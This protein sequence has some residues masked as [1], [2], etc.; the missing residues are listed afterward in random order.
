[1][2]SAA[3]VPEFRSLLELVLHNG[4][5]GWLARL[6]GKPD[7]PDY[8]RPPVRW[9]LS[10][11]LLAKLKKIAV[12]A[13][14][15]DELDHRDWMETQSIDLSQAG[16]ADG[17]PFWFDYV[18]DI[19]D[20]QLCN[21]NLACL[22]LG[23]LALR[24]NGTLAAI[25]DP[26]QLEQGES[27]GP[28]ERLPRGAFLLVGG[29]TAYQ[30]ADVE[31]LELR[32]H[33][34]FEWA[35]Q[36][37]DKPLA[38]EDERK[39]PWLF[40][41]PGNHDLYDAL[42]GFNKF[43]V[44]PHH[45]LANPNTRIADFNRRQTASYVCLDLPHGYR[46][47]GMDSQYGK[48]DHRQSTQMTAWVRAEEEPG[49]EAPLRRKLI[50][51]TSQPSTVFGATTPSSRR[52]FEAA[53]LPRPFLA[54]SAALPAGAIHLDLSGDIHHYARYAKSPST[55]W[56]NY[57]SVVAGGGALAHATEDDSKN[58]HA[59][60][61]PPRALKLYPEP[62]V[63]F[64]TTSRR[65][66]RPWQI[67]NGGLTWLVCG[68]VAALG[69]YGYVGGPF[70]SSHVSLLS[71]IT[72]FWLS[73]A[74][75]QGLGLR[76][77][78][79]FA[80]TLT[81]LL[82]CIR[83]TRFFRMNA[84][85]VGTATPKLVPT[86]AYWPVTVFGSVAL[87]S[88]AIGIASSYHAGSSGARLQS[89]LPLLASSALWPVFWS[90]ALKYQKTLPAQRKVRRTTW[91][92]RLIAALPLALGPLCSWY[93]ARLF[94]PEDHR[95]GRLS[96]A[97]GH[98]AIL[99]GLPLLA[100]YQGSSR[101]PLPRRALLVLAALLLAICLL[102]VPGAMAVHGS[103]IAIAIAVG[104]TWALSA[105]LSLHPARL[106]VRLLYPVSLVCPLAVVSVLDGVSPWDFIAAAPGNV[107][108]GW[109]AFAL[110]AGLA[111]AWF[112]GYLAFALSF[113]CHNNEAGGA[114]RIDRFGH[115][116]RFKLEPQ[117]I[118]GYV[119]GLEHLADSQSPL[120]PFLIEIF[121]VGQ[122]SDLPSTRARKVAE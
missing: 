81:T 118:T 110:G 10:R 109:V 97:V 58:E 24:E 34:P 104:V 46:L 72:Q 119:I 100:W 25:A 17:Q 39:E 87:A 29:D 18:A 55:D 64:S 103:P 95:L 112:G 28:N 14:F 83:C 70:L 73:V 49:A 57:Q 52:P 89:P 15:G 7:A 75:W 71:V 32:T 106:A 117:R 35:R 50:V 4:P 51:A 101:Q 11:E 20:G 121:H 43:F 69:A 44:K 102:L 98:L 115:F 6:Q 66:L 19:G 120:A 31:T 84:A 96:F 68:A 2:S 30:V 113:G 111:C 77:L 48:V 116:I 8:F 38:A 90:W 23:D 67:A 62:A 122:A 76:E 12:E 85:L 5:R 40:A 26:L 36:R 99:I 88:L 47:I 82:A 78:G 27:F 105:L 86:R 22:L 3:K 107:P 61:W 37:F 54:A 45:E 94:A 108:S 63:A 74:W 53:Q 91:R 16:Q 114:A 93:G 41:I 60:S 9:L 56:T 42:I 80:L 59:T 92:D 13:F 65:L 1:M 21:Y 33:L 79:T